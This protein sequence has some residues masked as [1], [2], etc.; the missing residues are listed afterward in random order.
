MRTQALQSL[1]IVKERLLKEGLDLR[2]ST[3]RADTPGAYDEIVI[4]HPEDVDMLQ[5]RKSLN[6]V[7]TD[8]HLEVGYI[9]DLNG[10]ERAILCIRPRYS[11]L[12]ESERAT[13]SIN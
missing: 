11:F 8:L 5:I 10:S 1:Q 7:G 12:L 9:R 2:I 4:H 13:L 3:V 6:G